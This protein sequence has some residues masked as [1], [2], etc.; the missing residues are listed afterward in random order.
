[1]TAGAHA[2]TA[3]DIRILTGRNLRVTLGARGIVATIVNPTLFFLAFSL[4]LRGLLTANGVD[5]G[6]AFPPAI[7]VLTAGFAAMSSGYALANDRAGG[8][9]TRLRTLPINTGALL[10][11]RLIADAVQ[12]LGFTAVVLALGYATG[13]HLQRGPLGALG[14]VVLAVAFGQ[15][16]A[17]GAAALG[18]RSRQPEAVGALVF[19]PFLALL[20]FSTAL[21]PLAAFPGWLQP[22]VRFS[23]L[24]AAVDALRALSTAGQPL[25]PV[26]HA[27]IWILCLAGLFGAAAR[28]AW[29]RAA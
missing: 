28:Q 5:F 27:A 22:F 16:L 3:Y 13:F 25:T 15:A 20:T 11:G 24:T 14:F 8:M 10:A 18:L 17:L 26:W 21:V 12:L 29:R 7:V 23:P 2:G 19:P 4:V 9:L 1:M 6:Q